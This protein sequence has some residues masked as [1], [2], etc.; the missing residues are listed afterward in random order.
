[1]LGGVLLARNDAWLNAGPRALVA[2]IADNADV[3]FP[4]RVP[5]QQET[6]EVLLFDIKRHPKCGSRDPLDQALDMQAA[7]PVIA[8]YFGGYTSEMQPIGE[9]QV[10]QLREAS[11]RKVAGKP[12]A[13]AG[14]DFK[15]IGLQ[16]IIWILLCQRPFG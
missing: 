14:A 4:V 12:S 9:R 7:M 16:W 8:G 1:M 6:H 3:K 15:N 13:G 10:K 11:E 5:I 2:F